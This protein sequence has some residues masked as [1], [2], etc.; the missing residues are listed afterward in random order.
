MRWAGIQLFLGKRWGN[1]QRMKNKESPLKKEKE[2]EKEEDE[3]EEEEKMTML[4]GIMRREEGKQGV[5][6][7]KFF[8]FDPLGRRRT[9]RQDR[10]SAKV[11]VSLSLLATA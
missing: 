8:L 5:P 11:F 7:I 10:Y 1:R 4:M 2:K 6:F 9:D 3:E